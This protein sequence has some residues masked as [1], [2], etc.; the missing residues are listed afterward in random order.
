MEP[1]YMGRVPYFHGKGVIQL[2][3]GKDENNTED[4]V[5]YGA[6]QM[7]GSSIYN[8]THPQM[9]ALLW[10]VPSADFVAMGDKH[11]YAYSE[12]PHHDMSFLSGLHA[13]RT[14]HL[15]QIGT[16]KNGPDHY[17]IRGW[18]KGN[19]EWPMF[20][21]Y[22]GE[23]KIKRCYDFEDLAHLLGVTI[24]RKLLRELKK[25]AEAEGG[26]ST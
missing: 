21:L 7:K 16:A 9:R 15:L 20:V 25:A 14:A 1:A 17:T 5:I 10:E 22:P 23:H 4:Y 26:F 12:V 8:P 24:D 3:V 2:K 19:F 11:Q 6:H 13:N 18:S